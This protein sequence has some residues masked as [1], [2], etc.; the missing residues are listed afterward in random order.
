MKKDDHTM[1]EVA[2]RCTRF[3]PCGCKS[4]S[5]QNDSSNSTQ[6]NVSCKFCAHYTEPDV[7]DIDLY[8]EI[9]KNHDL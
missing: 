2:E 6:E 5:C 4:G 9:V 7:C 3:S 1:K 8:R